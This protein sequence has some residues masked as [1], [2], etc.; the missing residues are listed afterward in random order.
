VKFLLQ[1][2]MCGV[3]GVHAHMLRVS[4]DEHGVLEHS[5]LLVF[6]DGQSLVA[7]L[8]LPLAMGFEMQLPIQV[9]F[10]R[11]QSLWLILFASVDCAVGRC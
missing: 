9:E 2:R 3:S 4:A 5:F 1:K 11:T 10:W 7:V 6:V 8:F